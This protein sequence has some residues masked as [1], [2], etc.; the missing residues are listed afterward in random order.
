MQKKR[1][2][3]YFQKL[4]TFSVLISGWQKLVG[5]FL[6]CKWEEEGGKVS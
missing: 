5:W 3:A 1:K 4:N 2:K 6:E